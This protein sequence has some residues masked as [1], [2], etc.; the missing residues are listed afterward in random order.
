[1][2][3]TKL[4]LPPLVYHELH[5]AR[6]AQGRE[7]WLLNDV[8]KIG[9]EVSK[10]T[11]CAYALAESTFLCCPKSS[12]HGQNTPPRLA[13]AGSIFCFYLFIARVIGV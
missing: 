5:L 7:S 8:T 12:A 9:D 1:M 6:D 4:D 3:V 13:R 2:Y 10:L 11:P